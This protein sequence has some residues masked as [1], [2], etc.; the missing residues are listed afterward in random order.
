ME[1]RATE[2]VKKRRS[3]GIMLNCAPLLGRA[4][5]QPSWRLEKR[6]KISE[7][8][9]GMPGSTSQQNSRTRM[10][11]KKPA[12]TVLMISF[13]E[14]APLIMAVDARKTNTCVYL[15]ADINNVWMAYL[16]LVWEKLEGCSR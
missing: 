9:L 14:L 8:E 15:Q 10:A 6:P 5:E 12:L 3:N 1:P 16:L 11:G 7:S 2:M 4:S 13:R